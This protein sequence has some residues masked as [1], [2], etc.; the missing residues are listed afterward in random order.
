MDWFYNLDAIICEEIEKGRKIAIYPLGKVGMQAKEIL[1]ERYGREAIVIDNKLA[2]YNSQ[3][4]TV[5][6]FWQN[7]DDDITV[8]LCAVDRK[9]ND[10]IQNDFMNRRKSDLVTLRN[11]IEPVVKQVPEKAAYF[12]Q[13]RDLCRVRKAKGYELTRVGREKDGGYIMLDDIQ[14]GT[15]AYSFGISNDVSWD[16][17]IVDRGGKVFCFDPSINELPEDYSGLFFSKIGI[18]GK[19]NVPKRLYSMK[20]ILEKNGHEEQSD[21]ILKMDVE[22]AEW[23]FL[24]ETSSELLGKFLQ[25]TFELHELTDKTNAEKIIPALEKLRLTHDPVWVHANNNGTIEEADGIRVPQFLEITYVNK[26]KY[27]L[28]DASYNCPIALDFPCNEGI[29]EIYLNNWGTND[30]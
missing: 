25:I 28:S 6:Q 21:M 17:D 20:T 13:L 15:I 18:T 10:V 2:K 5:E 27:D 30:I 3:I 4:M 7:V 1:N 12:R 14:N 16:K 29:L 19:D 26:E 8:I 22:G 11:I 24:Q 9:L 23:D